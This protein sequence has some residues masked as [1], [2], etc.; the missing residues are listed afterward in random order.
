MKR[1]GKAI[2]YV[3]SQYATTIRHWPGRRQMNGN[4]FNLGEFM[5]T[6]ELGYWPIGLIVELPGGKQHIVRGIEGVH[7]DPER[8]EY[9]PE[10]LEE[11]KS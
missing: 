8:E 3:S 7:D 1:S 6:L 4:R 10:W 9:P 11:I 2:H 5:D